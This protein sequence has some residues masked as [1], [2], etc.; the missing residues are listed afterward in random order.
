MPDDTSIAY[1]LDD[2]IGYLLRLASQ[3]HIAIFQQHMLHELTPTQFAAL[4]RLSEVG[5]CSQNDLGRRINVD[6]ATIK[7]V[8]DRLAARQLVRISKNPSD[9]RQKIVCIAKPAK[10]I[11][12]AL[13]TAGLEI[14]RATL[15]PLSSDERTQLAGLLHKLT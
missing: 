2:Q 7:G 3:R 4:I 11:L 1:C 10:V 13:R 6:V 8:V 14:S 12:T 15:A 5:C 9:R